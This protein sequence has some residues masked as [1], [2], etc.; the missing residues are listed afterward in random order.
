[1]PRSLTH[2]VVF[3]AFSLAIF[4]SICIVGVSAYDPPKSCPVSSTYSI[5]TGIDREFSFCNKNVSG[6]CMPIG[7]H[8]HYENGYT[9]VWTPEGTLVANISDKNSTHIF[10][11]NPSGDILATHSIEV[12]SGSYV[13]QEGNGKTIIASNI[14][15]QHIIAQITDHSQQSFPPTSNTDQWAAWKEIPINP[16]NPVKRL[17]AKWTVGTTPTPFDDDD[18][19]HILQAFHIFPGINTEDL[20]LQPVLSWNYVYNDGTS[21]RNDNAKKKRVVNKQSY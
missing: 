17:Y 21:H 9:T 5:I 18:S 16:E 3:V 1:M 10:S 20:I 15:K 7:A 4:A 2:F 8:I 19:R 6:Y 14:N 13:F 11:T 12:P